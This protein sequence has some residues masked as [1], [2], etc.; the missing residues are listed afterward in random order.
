MDVPR[1][2]G[3]S[4]SG[5]HTATPLSASI[6]TFVGLGGL[7][8]AEQYLQASDLKVDAF[9]F[10]GSFGA[11]AALL[12]A[13][14]AAPL[15]KARTTYYGHVLSIFLA[16]AVH[17]TA[18]SLGEIYGWA[19]PTEVERVLTPSLAIAAMVHYKLVHPPAAACVVI[20]TM[21]KDST[22]QLPTF[23][24]TPALL[25]C[26]YMLAVQYCTAKIVNGFASAATPVKVTP[27]DSKVAPAGA[28][29][30]KPP[31]GNVP[32][33]ERGL[34]FY[35]ADGCGG[36]DA[37]VRAAA[38]GQQHQPTPTSAFLGSACGLGGLSL[39]QYVFLEAGSDLPPA[40]TL[41]FIPSFGALATLLYASPA[42]PLG[43]PRNTYYG[44]TVSIS[45]AL[46]VHFVLGPLAT[47][48]GWAPPL[49]LEKG[50]G[51]GTWW[52]VR[53][54]VRGGR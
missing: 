33:A 36:L 22:Q 19:L 40:L 30:S 46:A 47:T 41:L 3:F 43:A 35:L 9:F 6:G 7:V 4:F 25:G 24:L 23:L 16:I 21:L 1:G 27:R 14:P 48:A 31:R 8:V 34:A 51:R 52:E 54:G 29:D 50:E 28:S 15:G 2:G 10:I 20:Y 26:T 45:V 37:L 42:A 18:L 11:L 13:A 53:V 32:E 5:A 49:G 44:H 12:Y 17:F 39:T 38:A